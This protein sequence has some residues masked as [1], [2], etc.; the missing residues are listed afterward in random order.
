MRKFICS[1]IAVFMLLGC[2][3]A[4][5]FTQNLS[6]AL[7]G[8]AESTPKVEEMMNAL[9]ENRAVD[10]KALMHPEI[11]EDCSS[12]IEQMCAYINGRKATH[13]E[14]KNISVNTSTGTSGNVRQENVVFKTTLSDGEEI[15]LNVSYRSDN[16]GVGFVSFQ[17]VLG[18]V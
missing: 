8:E 11:A 2:L 6:G 17:L 16:D 7:A 14:L 4:C 13:I 9:L 5:N 3:V 18:V 1:L 10:A 12:A 15:F